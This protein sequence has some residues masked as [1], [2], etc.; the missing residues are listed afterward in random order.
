[1]TLM[2]KLAMRITIL[3]TF[4]ILIECSPGIG[5]QIWLVICEQVLV[6]RYARLCE[7]CTPQTWN[8]ESNKTY[9]KNTTKCN[10]CKFGAHLAVKDSRYDKHYFFMRNEFTAQQRIDARVRSF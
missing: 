4:A 8:G 6:L 7:F 9:I 5:E 3:R 10:L 2:T 1:M